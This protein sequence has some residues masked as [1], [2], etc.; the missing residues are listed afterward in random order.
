MKTLSIS[1]EAF[2]LHQNSK[3]LITVSPRRVS[4]LFRRGFRVKSEKSDYV[5]GKLSNSEAFKRFSQ[6]HGIKT[7]PE[8][9]RKDLRYSNI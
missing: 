5:S 2:P 4:L 6:E 7:D 8:I 1:R 9:D 3:R